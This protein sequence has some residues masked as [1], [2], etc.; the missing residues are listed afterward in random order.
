MPKD[1][2]TAPQKYR[3]P[4][5]RN[6]VRLTFRKFNKAQVGKAIEAY[7]VC[8]PPTTRSPRGKRIHTPLTIE[9]GYKF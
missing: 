7:K 3:V 4:D 5:Q 8:V 6:G 1:V 9:P 2:P